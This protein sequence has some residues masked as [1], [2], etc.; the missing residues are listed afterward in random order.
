MYDVLI[1]GAGP[2]GLTLASELIRRDIDVR[3]IDAADGPLEG[4]RGKGI[5]PR[6]LEIFDMMGIID[7]VLSYGSLYP[8]LKIHLGVMAF[9]RGSLGT[10][11]EPSES[12][13][14]PNLMMVPQWRTQRVVQR[15]VESL[16]GKVE[17]SVALESLV[18][19]KDRVTVTLTNGETVKVRFLVGCDGGRSATR[20]ALRLPLIGE[21]LDNKTSIVADL[22]VEDLDREF[23]H[24][25]PLHRGGV[26]SLAPL[27]HTNLFQ[28]QAPERMADDGLLE[29]IKRTTGK[30]LI[31]VAWQ[32]RY[33]HQRRMAERY[34]VGRA[35]L[36]GDAAHIHPPA[37]AQGLNTGLQDAW[38]L[39]WKLAAAIRTGDD[40][41]LDTYQAERLP[42]AAN[43]LNLTSTLH[44]HQSTR[45][46]ELTNQ[47]SVGYRG[48]PL[49]RGAPVGDLHPGDR[50]PNERLADDR[51]LL[52]AMRHGGATLLKR[53]AGPNVL[54]RPDGYI[55]EFTDKPISDYFGLEVI[56]IKAAR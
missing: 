2:T 4:A 7:E 17:Y 16:G 34:R 48:G 43:M 6:S 38:N 9:K 32:S 13:P 3:L 31:R 11:H 22:E 8:F 33:K 46:G 24:A 51:N 23:W 53:S 44:T 47:L 35:F 42:I 21:T 1:A 29:G 41:I 39:G 10:H 36:A 50:M 12:R 55:A 30:R 5:Q 40:R 19:D 20:D 54:I 37:G 28:L 56:E 45:R 26:R 14:H 18:H 25:W 49:A 27:P 52:S 15:H